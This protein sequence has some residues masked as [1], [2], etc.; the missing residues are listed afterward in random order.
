MNQNPMQ[1]TKKLKFQTLKRTIQQKSNE[2]IWISMCNWNFK[3]RS[4]LKG[5]VKQMRCAS[6]T[7]SMFWQA[8][9][10]TREWLHLNPS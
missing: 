9:A 4:V 5:K 1:V 2:I 6:P 3:N 8:D 10:I 7:R